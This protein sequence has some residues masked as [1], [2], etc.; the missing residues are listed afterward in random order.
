M[1]H[2]VDDLKNAAGGER[3]LIQLSNDTGTGT[4]DAAALAVLAA[5][6]QAAAD[7]IDGYLRDRYTLPLP[8]PVPG[9]IK[10][11]SI[12]LTLYRLFKRRNKG[13][14]LEGLVKEREN[15]LRYLE[16]VQS[17]KIALY[18]AQPAPVS[19]RV[20]KAATDKD[21]TDATFAAY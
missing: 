4:L 10:E 6:G 15:G 5:N 8:E 9:I 21:F 20:N 19:V 17:G 12:S 13:E 1:Y 2:T 7:T 11:I 3:D 14:V 16:H 18:A